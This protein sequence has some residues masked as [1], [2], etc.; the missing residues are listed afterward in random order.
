MG[1]MNAMCKGR[2]HHAKKT[3]ELMAFILYHF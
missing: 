3:R 1:K 2:L